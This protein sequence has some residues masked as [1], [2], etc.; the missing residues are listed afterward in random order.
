MCWALRVDERMVCVVDRMRA[1]WR[2]YKAAKTASS[3]Y[4]ACIATILLRCHGAGAVPRR[5]ETTSRSVS[6]CLCLCVCGFSVFARFVH[7][8]V[9]PCGILREVRTVCLCVRAAC[10]C[11]LCLLSP[12]RLK[13]DN[14]GGLK[15]RSMLAS[16]RKSNRKLE[17]THL[18]LSTANI[19]TYARS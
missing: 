15:T 12:A 11:G 6:G 13:L 8:Y 19:Y 10:C 7:A 3:S 2:R 4:R 16:A 17:H 14:L 1:T 18:C 5:K 9:Q